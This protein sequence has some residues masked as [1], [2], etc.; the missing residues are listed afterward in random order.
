MALYA[1][2][3]TGTLATG[4]SQTP[5][6]VITASETMSKVYANV[7]T[8]PTGQSILIDIN[9]NGSTIWSTQSNRVAIAA[10]ATAG[11][12][13]SFDT[14]ALVQGDV[15]TFDIDQVGSGTAGADLTIEVKTT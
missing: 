14:T 15:L 8:A 5:I 4:T 3:V 13:T 10:A 12:Q 2:A 11:T 7:K 1:V 6:V 9:L